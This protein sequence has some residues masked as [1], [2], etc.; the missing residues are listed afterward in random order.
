MGIWESLATP[1]DKILTFCNYLK[2]LPVNFMVFKLT[3]TLNG[4]LM[5]VDNPGLCNSM[6]LHTHVCMFCSYLPLQLSLSA[7]I[8]SLLPRIFTSEPTNHSIWRASPATSGQ[9]ASSRFSP[10]CPTHKNLSLMYQTTAP[11]I[12]RRNFSSSISS[13]CSKC[14]AHFLEVIAHNIFNEYISIPTEFLRSSV[15]HVFYP[16]KFGAFYVYFQPVSPARTA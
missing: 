13:N 3:R 12:G 10:V 15:R 6:P 2:T 5:Y 11:N 7:S 14:P 4:D 9:I 1:K 8:S 16:S